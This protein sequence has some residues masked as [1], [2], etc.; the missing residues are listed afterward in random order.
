[1][2]L[3][4]T[5]R[6]G[7]RTQALLRGC[8]MKLRQ[9]TEFSG[10]F[11]TMCEAQQQAIAR[12]IVECETQPP[13]PGPAFLDFVHS[14]I[15][16]RLPTPGGYGAAAEQHVRELEDLL[17]RTQSLIALGQTMAAL[18]HQLSEPITAIGTHAADCRGL[19]Q[20]N[21]REEV[22]GVLQQIVAQSDQA[23][24]IAQS[25]QRLVGVSDPAAETPESV[26]PPVA[27]L[28]P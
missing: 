5:T 27:P 28:K 19:L 24:Q 7:G 1:M 4:E 12:L 22:D 15:A 26:P 16:S 23:L 10:T 11:R 20:G 3:R 8:A 14:G 17:T 13:N 2:D 21:R 18:L 25:M 9:A 6:V